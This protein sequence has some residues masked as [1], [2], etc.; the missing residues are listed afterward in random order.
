MKKLLLPLAAA[1]AF[2]LPATA[3]A[4]SFGGVV[5]AKQPARH[6][7]VV[8]A[9]GVVRTVHT[10]RAGLA[11]GARVAVKAKLLAD[12]TFSATSV[13]TRGRA[14]T[15]RIRGVVARQ[16]KTGYMVAA[17]HSM[18]AVRTRKLA[19]AGA[20]AT[21]PATGTIVDVTVDTNDNELDQQE[22]EEQGHAER[23]ELE[24]TISSITFATA[25]DPGDLV[26]TVGKSTIDVVI[27]AGTSLPATLA[28]GDKVEVKV[29]LAGDT[30][31]LA[32]SHEEDSNQGEDDGGHHGGDDHGGHHHGGG[33]D[34]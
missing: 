33:G 16:L 17:G 9:A 30:F 22:V 24:G 25:T 10:H 32:T 20:G 11:V 27:P 5:V 1:V 8:S 2:V 23:L 6:A 4:A 29:T 12:G 13:V 26:L 7:V 3:G 15:A 18:L 31:T 14:K 34:G 21:G 28:I 19:D